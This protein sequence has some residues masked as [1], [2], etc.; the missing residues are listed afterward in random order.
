MNPYAAQNPYAA[1]QAPVM[2]AGYA[3][4]VSPLRVEG[5]LLVAAN[6][7]GLPAVCLKCGSTHGIGWRDQKFVWV[8]RWAVLFGALIQ[9]IVA[10]RSRFNL[11]LCPPCTA[12]WKKWNLI[13]W[14]SWLPG[15][16]LFLVG[17]ALSGVQA[18]GAAGALLAIFG[19]VIVLAGLLTALVLRGR[20]VV[21]PTKIDKTHT[22]LRGVHANA[23]QT[24]AAAAAQAAYAQPPAAAPGYYPQQPPPGYAYPP[25]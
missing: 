18:A 10:K 24:M 1:P 9:A 13:A 4:G 11:P 20:A 3:P 21:Y 23:L 17:V 8:P 12:R 16:F 2:P 14:L 7:S 15:A 25:S 19:V 6:G 5:N 22:W